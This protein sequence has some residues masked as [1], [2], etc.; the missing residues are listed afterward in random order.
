MKAERAQVFTQGLVAGLIAYAAVALFFFLVNAIGGRSPFHTAAV[1]G[2][3]LFYGVG[4]ATTVVIEPGPIIAYNG[5]HLIVSLVAGT[6]GAWLFYETERHHWLWYLVFF[7]FLAGFVY[8]LVFVGVL[9]AE[10][11]ELVAWPAVAVANVIWVVAL[12]GYL[13]YQHRGL[14]RELRD[15]QGSAT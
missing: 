11:S 13:L 7:I 6:I 15:E 1:L 14:I 8:S 10:I 5:L 9:S 12:G 2:S 4:D 3:A